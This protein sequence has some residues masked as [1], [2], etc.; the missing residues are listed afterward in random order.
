MVL[1][2]SD[3]PAEVYLRSKGEFEIWRGDGHSTSATLIAPRLCD[4]TPCVAYLPRGEHALRFVDHFDD[5]RHAEARVSVR[6]P[7]VAVQQRLDERQSGWGREGV[8][9][10]LAGGILGGAATI[11]A[12]ARTERD[13][14]T[15]KTGVARDSQA[16]VAAG[17]LGSGALFTAGAIVVV[18][19]SG[20]RT[21]PGATRQ[22]S[23]GPSA[24]LR[25][26]ARF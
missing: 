12:V 4:E 26:G 24:G 16:L 21:V 9:M 8:L 3:R 17:V 6:T 11:L 22:W 14:D 20:G 25:L 7:R 5:S 15:G 1:I 2:D 10:I 18:A 23:P 13:P 19:G